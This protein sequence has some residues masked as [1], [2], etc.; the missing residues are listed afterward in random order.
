MHFHTREGTGIN[1]D[2]VL[3]RIGVVHFLKL[4]FMI[5]WLEGKDL[6]DTVF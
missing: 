5:L 3:F 6:L 1:E 2:T 4:Q